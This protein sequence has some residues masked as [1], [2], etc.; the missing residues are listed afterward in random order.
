MIL[1]ESGVRDP[2]ARRALVSMFEARKQVFVDLLGWNVPVIGGRLEI[3]QFD[4]ER[5]TYIIVAGEDGDHLGSARLLESERPHIL[6]DL[7]PELCAEA[8]PTGPD[9]FEITRFCLG[10]TQGSARRRE[11]RNQL[12]SALVAHALRQGIRTYTGVA[13]L[14]WLQQILAFGWDCRPLG[15]PRQL[16]CGLTGALAI[17][18]DARTPALLAQN[19]IWTSGSE[20]ALAEAA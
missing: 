17:A 15:L 1:V 7:Y 3:D 16:D 5:A 11:T 20:P 8:V 2:R 19:G 13:Q 9:V 18:I 14:G 4:D 6:G 12:V 10:R